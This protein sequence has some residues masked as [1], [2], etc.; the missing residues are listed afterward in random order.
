MAVRTSLMTSAPSR[1][2]D[3]D[4]IDGVGA[5]ASSGV[6]ESAGVG[7]SRGASARAGASEGAEPSAR[8]GAPSQPGDEAA[9]AALFDANASFVWR[10]LRRLGVPDADAD[11][12]VQDVFIVVHRRLGE[13]EERGSVRSWLFAIARQVASHRRRTRVRR[14]RAIGEL[15]RGDSSPDDPHETAMRNEAVSI[16]HEFMSRLDEPQALVF[17]LADV[18][19]MTAPE[20]AASLEVNVNTVYGRL[21]LARQQF[22]AFLARRVPRERAP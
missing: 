9:F 15:P 8:A 11:D 6:C 20:I 16:V 13:Y 14:D 4:D 5:G 22:E 2:G 21:R 10:V 12:A 3:R 19:G 1:P 18:E 17:F 7:T